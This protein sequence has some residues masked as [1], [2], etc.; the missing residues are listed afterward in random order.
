MK[1]GKL[2]LSL[3]MMCL[4][5]AVLCFGVLAATSVTYTISGT[6]SYEVKDAYVEITTK[7][8]TT[9]TEYEKASDLRTAGGQVEAGTLSLGTGTQVGTTYNTLNETGTKENS[10]L[11]LT[12]DL[13]STTKVRTNWLVTEVKNLSDA[14][15]YVKVIDDHELDFYTTNSFI[16]RTQDVTSLA[17]KGTTKIVIGFTLW[18]ET[19]QIDDASYGFTLEIGLAENYSPLKFQ[20]TQTITTVAAKQQYTKNAYYYVEMGDFYGLPVRW[21]L[22][23][24][25]DTSESAGDGT[26][27]GVYKYDDNTKYKNIS[28]ATEEGL[29]KYKNIDGIFLQETVTGQREAGSY[30]GSASWGQVKYCF[31]TER[32]DGEGLTCCSFNGFK[33]SGSNYYKTDDSGNIVSGVLANDYYNSRIRQYLNGTDVNKYMEYSGVA[34]TGGHTSNYLTD[35]NISTSNSIYSK[36]TARTSMEMKTGTFSSNVWTPSTTD[37]GSGKTTNDK[38]W[39]PSVEEMLTWNAGVT[40]STAWNESLYDKMN[41]GYYAG[42]PSGYYWDILGAN[43]GLRSGHSSSVS[44]VHYVYING[45]ANNWRVNS[46]GSGARAA[47]NLALGE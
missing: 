31:Y 40:T 38:F 30:S 22:I 3:A 2:I 18:D 35:L 21:K 14:E 39:L 46:Y 29:E 17:G 5:V 16:Y 23:A 47:F 20:A 7:K 19:T 44:Y 33:Q 9:T 15:L 1:R 24:E 13:S 36:I 34:H 28:T 42:K 26:V 32:A 8:Y 25:K 41:W 11:A 43:A 45:S 6:I 37:Y 12:Y 10:G 4:S 27:A